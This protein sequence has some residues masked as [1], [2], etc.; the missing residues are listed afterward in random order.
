[1]P[2]KRKPNTR[3]KAQYRKVEPFSKSFKRFLKSLPTKTKFFWIIGISLILISLGWRAHEASKLSFYFHPAPRIDTALTNRP[4]FITIKDLHILLPIQETAIDNGVWQI[5]DNGASHLSIS[6]RPGESGPIIIY[7][8]NTNNRFGSL[9][10][11]S[12]GEEILIT[13]ADGKNHVYK[14]TQTMTVDPHQ[15][16]ILTNQKDE[17]LILYTC[18]GFADLQRF[19]VFATPADKPN[20]DADVSE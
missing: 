16:D 6:A 3:K 18:T 14:V 9:P 10:Y 4:T 15:T 5:D 7:A 13:T 17:T 12:L 11:A 20:P 8:H 1:M 2:R 19:V